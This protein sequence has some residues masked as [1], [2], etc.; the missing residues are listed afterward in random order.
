MD[1]R[2]QIRIHSKSH[3]SATLLPG[4]PALHPER[5]D[6]QV[7]RQGYQPAG[8]RGLQVEVYVCGRAQP[9]HRLSDQSAAL[10]TDGPLDRRF[11]CV[12][13]FITSKSSP[14]PPPTPVSFISTPNSPFKST[15]FRV[16][17]SNGVVNP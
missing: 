2:I 17:V 14:P 10:V 11:V 15:A 9:S 5:A 12:R 8:G 7:E 16:T 6:G 1:P 4:H 3:G 13:S